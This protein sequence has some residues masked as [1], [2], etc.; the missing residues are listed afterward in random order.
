LA[1]EVL[2]AGIGVAGWLKKLRDDRKLLIHAAAQAQKAADYILN[3]TVPARDSHFYES[4]VHR[5][6]LYSRIS[7]TRTSD[8]SRSQSAADGSGGAAPTDQASH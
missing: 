7:T 2:S 5:S 8:I 4:A 6:T 1:L 3:R